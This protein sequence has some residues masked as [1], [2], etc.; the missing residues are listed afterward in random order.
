MNIAPATETDIE[1]L[2]QVEVASKLHSFA[3]NEDYAIDYQGRLYR[4]QTYFKGESPA[5]A[6]PE[7]ITLK[8]IIDGRIIGYIS[9]HLTARHGKDAEIESF[10]VLKNHQR[11]GVGSKLLQPFLDWIISHQAKSLCVGTYPENPYKAFYVKYGGQ[12]LNPHWI[13]WD[14]LEL[15]KGKIENKIS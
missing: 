14:D 13:Y 5:S 15:L 10:Y 1:E 2:A 11:A 12:Y 3:V 4:W 9:G 6:R 7:R 8:A